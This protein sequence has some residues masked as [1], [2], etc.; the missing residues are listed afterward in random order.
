[1]TNWTYWRRFYRKF[2]WEIAYKNRVE[3]MVR[4][5]K[6]PN[7]PPVLIAMNARM[8]LEAH[9]RGRWWAVWGHVKDAAWNH[10]SERYAP[11]WEWIRTKV[12]RLPRDPDLVLAERLDEEEA[13]LSEVARQL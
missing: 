10:Y 3:G 11:A 2:N 5:S 9:Y 7:A 8:I 12:F 6:F 4:W 13:A 1:M